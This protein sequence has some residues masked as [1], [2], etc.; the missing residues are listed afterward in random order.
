MKK[1]I[2]DI[3]AKKKAEP[4]RLA[5]A[6]KDLLHYSRYMFSD[7]HEVDFMEA[8][9]HEL[10]C[11]ALMKVLSGEIK[12]LLITI[13]PSYGKTEFAVKLFISYALGNFPWFRAI[14][15]TYSDDLATETPSDVKSMITSEAYTKV[16]GEKKLLKTADKKWY[17]SKNGKKDGGMYSTTIEGGIT[18]FHGDVLIIDDAMKAIL[19]NN[20]A[21]RDTTKEFYTGSA[22]TRLRKASPIKA[23]ICIMQR[24]HKDDLPGYLIEEEAGLWTHINLTGTE[25]K[26]Q[27]YKFFEFYYERPAHEPLNTAMEDAEALQKQK[28][29]MK[30]NW[31]SQY[32]QDPKTIETGYI[33]DDEFTSVASWELAEDNKCI[34]IDPAQSIKETAD[35][36]AISLIG[37]SE[38]KEKIELF[39][40]Y[41]TWFGKWTNDVFVEHIITVM[42]DNPRVP[43]FMESSG[44]GI[45]TE[46]NLVKALKIVNAERKKEGKPIVT[47]KVTLFNPKTSI[48]KNQ[49]IEDSVDTYLKKHQIRFVIGGTGQEQVKKE[50]KGFHP[51]K[52]SAEDDCIETIANVVVND[53]I[54]AKTP[55][56]N[57]TVTMGIREMA[58]NN[59]RTGW[60]I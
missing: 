46:Q 43:V 45:L 29:T 51:E 2:E 38:N 31:Y 26:P 40:I 10:I 12:N 11:L 17:I 56:K 4:I 6:R 24:L 49:K 25:P 8:W 7:Y 35:N 15:A 60:R 13:P 54:T 34:S 41:G 44:G 5:L 37:V 1:D 59:K 36:R 30:E 39:N 42:I 27:I 32:M 57:T 53:F 23:I 55:K 19:K 16:F 28:E 14:Y 47:N 33:T 3:L 22:S 9:Y 58:Q 52:D 21:A 18:G 20:K 50:Y 48:S